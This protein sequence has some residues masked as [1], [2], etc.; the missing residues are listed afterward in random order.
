MANEFKVKNGIKFADNTVQTTA[1]TGG[2]SVSI[3]IAAPGSPT[4][5]SL[6]WDS[7][8]GNLK[9]YYNDGDTSQWVDSMSTLV[10]GGGAAGTVTSVGGTGTVNGLTLTGTVTTTG[11]LTLG[12]TLDLSSP[13]AIGGTLAA[14]GTFTNITSATAPTNTVAAL[15]LTG[16]PNGAVG[17]K[18]G[19][20]AVGSTF[21]AADKNILASFVQNINDYTQIIV[22]NPNA[23]AAASAD[24]VVN[25][26]NTTGA[27]TYG[28]FGINS[29]TFSGTGSFA[30]PNASYLYS[31]GG[32]L[33]IGT[34]SAN[35]IRFVTNTSATDAASI[36][37]AG[38]FTATSASL[39]TPALSAP[40]YSTTNNLT[41][42]TNAQGQG[43]FTT[44]NVIV[45]TTAANPSGVTLP[46]AT[47]GRTIT[48]TNKGTNPINVYPATGGQIDGAGA[49]VAISVPVGGW[50]EFNAAGG[51]QWYST[52]NAIVNAGSIQ[53]NPGVQMGYTTTATAGGST[54]LTATSSL[55]QYFT[56]TANQTVVLPVTTTLSVGHRFRI[57][58]ESTGIITLNTSGG[59]LVDT[60]P[61]GETMDITCI[62]ASGTTAASWAMESTG[63]A[64]YTVGYL[65]VP[66][67]AQ[68]GAYGITWADSGKHIYHA[69][70][71]A[72]ATYTIPA[73]S[74][75]AFPIGTAI[76][77]VNMATAAVTI[78]ITTDTMYLAGAGTTGSRTL[79]QFG[80]ATALK[81][82]ATEWI[83]SGTN[84]T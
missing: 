55:A 29:S 26:D 14:A 39:T 74:A 68:T 7:T 46:T 28:D 10:G 6:W 56:G 80:S 3:G 35:G 34:Q 20:L 41:A 66:Q 43:A 13:P 27:G 32:E 42:G 15:S 8:Y 2:T 76:S 37:S 79:A 81:T 64:I 47:T 78:A 40:T 62:L 83:I 44:D 22:Q 49:N 33:V 45:T 70:A 48:L 17:G 36:T 72:A 16:T 53:G 75:I 73:N 25:N 84:L 71:A 23:G 24:F 21:T 31:V 65:E 50:I 67:N 5:G 19:V 63:Q 51:T 4:A 69:L 52:L 77:F 38:V 54:T 57:S 11:N 82:G 61:P 58:N 59:S 12:G 9:I 1:A 60:M 30:L 18:L